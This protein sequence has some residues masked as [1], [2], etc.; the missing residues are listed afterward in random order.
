[1]MAV[2]VDSAGQ[3]E[4]DF[5]AAVAEVEVGG[6]GD[7]DL[8]LGG[9]VVGGD[10][11]ELVGVGVL[12][13]LDDPGGDDLVGRPDRAGVLGGDAHALGDRQAVGAEAAQLQAGQ[14]Q[15]AGQLGD[16]ESDVNVFAQPAQGD[17]HRS[18]RV[19]SGAVEKEKV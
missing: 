2:P 13:D 3:A 19:N 4:D 12:A 15:A 8:R 18:I 14:R 11:L 7:D 1:D 6:A 5:L 10:E 16:R 17:F 9:A